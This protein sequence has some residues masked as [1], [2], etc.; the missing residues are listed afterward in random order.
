MNPK[1]FYIDMD[2]VLVLASGGCLPQA[3][4]MIVG[5]WAQFGT[6]R[7]AVCPEPLSAR[8]ALV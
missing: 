3:E 4:G 8:L 6:Y 7:K 1:I 2:N 5:V